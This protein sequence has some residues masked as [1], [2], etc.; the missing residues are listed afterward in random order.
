VPIKLYV[1]HGSPPSAAVARAMDMKGLQYDV[2]ELLPPLHAAVQRIRFGVRT[3]PA[4]KLETG[5]KLSGSRRIIRRLE[6]LA[7]QP[8]LFPTDEEERAEVERAEEWGDEVWQ[9]I[10]RRFLWQGLVQEPRAIVSYREGSRIPVPTPLVRLMAPVA[11]GIGGKLNAA[12]ELAV[13]ADLRS[14]ASHL[15]RIDGWLERGVLGTEVPNAADL[16]IASS[17][18]MMLSVG[19]V[20]PSFAG[21]PAEEHALRLF[22][23]YDGSTPAG[24]FPSQWTTA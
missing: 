18:R 8:S 4:I 9:P 22:P 19:D 20:R 3:V 13:R 23:H 15:D 5:E 14:L 6:E 12:S 10:A 24:A 2:V 11:T 16:Q 1:V 21:R 7:P 17:S